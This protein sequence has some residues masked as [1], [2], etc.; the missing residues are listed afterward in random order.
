MVH[1]IQD[2]YI[3]LEIKF[4]IANS[5]DF[6]ALK[7]SPGA[8]RSFY[9]SSFITNVLSTLW[10]MGLRPLIYLFIYF[11]VFVYGAGIRAQGLGHVLYYGAAPL[12]LFPESFIGR[13]HLSRW[14]GQGQVACLFG[15][16]ALRSEDWPPSP[17][18]GAHGR[19]IFLKQERSEGLH[20][21]ASCFRSA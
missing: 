20:M 14:D 18:A 12:K 17:G 16:I 10:P 3:V 15:G 19:K 1:L 7:L 2:I 21:L 13:F 8:S 9:L 5:P 4:R 11:C 6:M